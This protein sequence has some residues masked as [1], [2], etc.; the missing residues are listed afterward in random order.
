MNIEFKI[1]YTFSMNNPDSEGEL[2]GDVHVVKDPYDTEIEERFKD[3]EELDEVS[4][5][6]APTKEGLQPIHQKDK[7]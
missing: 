4:I 6:I 7:W 1:F 3:V 2:A 5:I